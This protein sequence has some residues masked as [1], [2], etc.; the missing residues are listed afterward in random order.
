MRRS[1]GVAG[2]RRA[3]G[4]VRRQPAS[5]LRDLRPRGGGPGRRRGG[6]AQAGCD[7]AVGGQR[8]ARGLHHAAAVADQGGVGAARAQ[9]RGAAPRRP[10]LCRAPEFRVSFNG[11]GVYGR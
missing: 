3:H 2:G 11:R 6:G 1:V 4:V 5:E 9:R 7:E 10:W 8:G